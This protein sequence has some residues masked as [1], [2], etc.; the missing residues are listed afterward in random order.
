[1][2]PC[3]HLSALL[4]SLTFVVSA[5]AVSGASAQL[6][7]L[8]IEGRF[9][10]AAT[11]Q[12]IISA[13]M[14]VSDSL[15]PKFVFVARSGANGQFSAA[16]YSGAHYALW[17][18]AQGYEPVCA[19]VDLKADRDW[20]DVSYVWRIDM[21]VA[22]KPV[23][24]DVARPAGCSWR[25]VYH[26]RNSR[27]DWTQAEPRERFPVAVLKNE[28]SDEELELD[29]KNTDNRLLLVKGEVK[30][31]K[32]DRPLSGARVLF[33]REGARDTTATTN[34]RGEYEMRL[35]FDR[36][37]RMRFE[38][39][40]KVAKV[41]EIDPRSVPEKERKQGFVAWTDINLFDPVPGAD[42]SFLNEPIGKAAYSAGSGTIEWD[43]EYSL[44]IVERLNALLSGH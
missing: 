33:S 9:T 16:L 43:M 31:L 1:M 37:F 25:C 28:R 3:R 2:A 38:A 42:L 27:L 5:F 10:D 17:F 41:V 39:D 12:P 4:R 18:E 19:V 34:A 32:N 20:P 21:P 30:D 26:P 7:K 13:R 29:W 23:Q 36:I 6:E 15:D 44:P 40:G 8:F 11:G 24:A 14:T 35:P 22:L